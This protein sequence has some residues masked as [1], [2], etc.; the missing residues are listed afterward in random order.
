LFLD[1][2]NL[3][4]VRVVEGGEILRFSRKAG[5]AFGIRG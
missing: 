5:D 3:R 2:V 1:A 4:D